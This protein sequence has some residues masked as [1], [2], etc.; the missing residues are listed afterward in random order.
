MKKQKLKNKNNK[1]KLKG[2]LSFCINLLLFSIKKIVKMF[3]IKL[4][5]VFNTK[6]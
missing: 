6:K 3:T 4:R 1:I 5:N 2:L